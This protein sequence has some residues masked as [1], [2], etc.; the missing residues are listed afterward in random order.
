MEASQGTR[1]RT[2][3]SLNKPMMYAG[4]CSP[5]CLWLVKM[6]WLNPKAY[7]LYLFD[8][9]YTCFP[10]PAG[11]FLEWGKKVWDK[12]LCLKFQNILT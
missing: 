4:D 5:F 6:C 3:Q 7:I 8:W 10:N 11:Y 12:F 1:L 2:S 9:L